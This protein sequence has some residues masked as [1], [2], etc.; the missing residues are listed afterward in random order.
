MATSSQARETIKAAMQSEHGGVYGTWKA[1]GV[2]FTQ[3][4]AFLRG[5]SL[6]EANASRL[7]AALPTVPNEVW[8]DAF[9]PM[10]QSGSAEATA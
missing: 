2:H 9:A 7:R 3:L 1:C 6:V 4:Y 10:P 5:G 8:A